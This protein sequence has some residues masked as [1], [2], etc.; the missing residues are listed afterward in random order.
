MFCRSYILNLLRAKLTN[1]SP[2]DHLS[3]W[4]TKEYGTGLHVT[5]VFGQTLSWIIVAEKNI[6]T[7]NKKGGKEEE[8]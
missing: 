2:L 4:I 7:E 8:K 5:K 3:T 6:I 1:E